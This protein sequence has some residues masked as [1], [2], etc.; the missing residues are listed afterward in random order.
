L[1]SFFIALVETGSTAMNRFGAKSLLLGAFD[2]VDDGPPRV[3]IIQWVED[4]R[5]ARTTV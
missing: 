2:V 3:A 5:A 1:S 4:D